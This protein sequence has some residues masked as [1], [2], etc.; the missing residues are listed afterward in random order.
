MC[1]R[2]ESRNEAAEG[3]SK[4]SVTKVVMASPSACRLDEFLFLKAC[5]C[6][7]TDNAPQRV[8][9]VDEEGASHHP[10]LSGVCWQTN[11]DFFSLSFSHQ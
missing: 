4:G 10:S 6:C 3:F 2:L 5:Q 9:C 1:F 8:D 11:G 7:L